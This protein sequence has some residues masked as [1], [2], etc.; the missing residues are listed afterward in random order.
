MGRKKNKNKN[1]EEPTVDTQEGGEDSQST[2][3]VETEVT[4]S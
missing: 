1:N 2:E 3:K 4:E